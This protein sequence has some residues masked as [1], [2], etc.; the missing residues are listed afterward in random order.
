MK[1]ISK[2]ENHYI[3][4]DCSSPNCI[5]RYTLNDYIEGKD[6]WPEIVIDFQLNRYRFFKRLWLAIKYLFAY[7]CEFGH[8]DCVLMSGENVKKLRDLCDRHLE[9][10]DKYWNKKE[11]KPFV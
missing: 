8:W 9:Q 11:L 7:K 5:M 4:C 6:Y 3:E 10:M 2:D 1:H